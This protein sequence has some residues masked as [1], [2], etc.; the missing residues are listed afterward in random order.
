MLQVALISLP[1]ETY[2]PIFMK[3]YGSFCTRIWHIK[4]DEFTKNE[5]TAGCTCVESP[6]YRPPMIFPCPCTELMRAVTYTEH[7]QLYQN[8]LHFMYIG[9]STWRAE[10]GDHKE[11]SDRES[12]VQFPGILE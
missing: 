9:A 7:T 12:G 10:G 6:P 5:K 2:N 1:N 3:A 11:E 8:A 4:F